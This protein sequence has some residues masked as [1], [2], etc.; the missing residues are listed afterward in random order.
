MSNDQSQAVWEEAVFTVAL[1]LTCIVF[2]VAAAAVAIHEETGLTSRSLPIT[3]SVTISVYSAVKAISLLRLARRHQFDLLSMDGIAAKII[4]PLS[5]TMILYVPMVM[6]FGYVIG[7]MMVLMTVLRVFAVRD[8]VFNFAI[9]VTVGI[10]ADFVFVDTLGMFMPN[11][12]LIET[13]H[14]LM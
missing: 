10:V 4:L 7:T 12:W 3:L 8:L 1:M 6:I 2:S 14:E 9:S 13:V 11:G 5:V